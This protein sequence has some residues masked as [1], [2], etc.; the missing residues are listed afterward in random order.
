MAPL[1]CVGW[2]RGS[3]T[4][5]VMG[6]SIVGRSALVWRGGE[7][8]AGGDGQRDGWHGQRVSALCWVL[9]SAMRIAVPKERDLPSAKWGEKHEFSKPHHAASKFSTACEQ[10]AGERVLLPQPAYLPQSI[11]SHYHPQLITRGCTGSK[12]GAG[13]PMPGVSWPGLL[14]PSLCKAVEVLPLPVPP[15]FCLCLM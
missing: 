11:P 1:I 7:A 2:G 5:S 8:G 12:L 10:L 6:S 4:R 14:L 3:P 13:K 9:C 15:L